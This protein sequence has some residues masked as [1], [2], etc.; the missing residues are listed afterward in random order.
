MRYKALKIGL[1]AIFFLVVVTVLWSFLSRRRQMAVIP[2][3]SLLPSAVKR[4]IVQFEYDERKRGKTVF[5]VQAELSTESEQGV[6]TLRNVELIRY[7]AGGK[8]SDTVSARE[9]VYKIAQ[10]QIEFSG[11]VRIEL[12]DQTKIFSQQTR[13][14]LNKEVIFIDESF[15]FDQGPATGKGKSLTY[16]VPGKEVEVAGLFQLTIPDPPGRLELQA[17]GARYH[18]SRGRI[19]L[20]GEAEI[21]D[22]KGRLSGDRMEILLTGEKQIEEIRATGNARF[23]SHTR[24]TFSGDQIHV[25]I[26][27]SSQQIQYFEVLGPPRASYE[28]KTLEGVHHLEAERIRGKIGSRD[29]VL[30][31]ISAR[32]NVVFHSTALKI[33]PSSADRLTAW[34]L[35]KDRKLKRLELQGKVRL[36]RNV[37][38]VSGVRSEKFRGNFLRLDF[39]AHQRLDLVTARGNVDMELNSERGYRHLFAKESVL[40]NYRSGVLESIVSKKDCVLEGQDGSGKR[41]LRAPLIHAR[42]REGVLEQVLAEGGVILESTEEGA[43]RHTSS[44]RLSALYKEGTLFQATQSGHFHFWEKS[45]F[46]EFPRTDLRA[47]RAVFTVAQG[48]V[49]ITGKKAPVLESADTKTSARRFVVDRKT[50]KISAFEEVR[51]VLW[52]EETVVTASHME[53]DPNTGWV[54][55]T[56]NPRILREGSVIS[57]RRVRFNSNSQQLVVEEKVESVLTQESEAGL[58]KYWIKADHLLYLRGQL[59]ARYEGRVRAK[60]DDLGVQSLFLDVFFSC[61]GGTGP[62]EIVARGGVRMTHRDRKAEGDRAVYYPSEEKVVLTGQPA[63]VFE[64]EKGKSSGGQLTFYIRENKI[65]VEGPLNSTEKP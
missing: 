30:K 27:H 2:Q 8:A 5:H 58:K 16:R 29:A 6:H 4:R 7:D 43:T 59:L 17:K 13:A 20:E 14:D 44:E 50:S 65:L 39:L 42:Y 19:E 37:Q 12:S 35:G 23:R 54:E 1:I 21:S 10:K 25:V 38:A 28:E 41:L 62:R 31:Q 33:S 61:P 15:S 18:V 22:P 47:E 34:F 55:Y 32:G 57:G 63:R 9:A 53:A 56:G 46:G 49:R 26:D 40:A 11:D 36:A 52:E 51:S 24:Q 3:G 64:A 48:K 60:T 45:D